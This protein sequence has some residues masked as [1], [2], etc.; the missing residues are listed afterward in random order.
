VAVATDTTVTE[1]I[2]LWETVG[3]LWSAA[4]VNNIHIYFYLFRH[5]FIANCPRITQRNRNFS[6]SPCSGDIGFDSRPRDGLFRQ[7]T[8]V[9]LAGTLVCVQKKTRL[10]PWLKFCEVKY[11]FMT[12]IFV[13]NTQIH[14]L[15]KVK[16]S[17]V[18]QQLLDRV[19]HYLQCSTV[20]GLVLYCDD[21]GDVD[22]A[23]DDVLCVC[24]RA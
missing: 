7:F 19:M 4:P 2:C 16:C 10:T 3:N 24:A 13:R 23:A 12:S 9:I 15:W 17:S 1:L 20:Y 22:A 8:Q 21:D 11:F 5:L 14:L 18:Y 6:L